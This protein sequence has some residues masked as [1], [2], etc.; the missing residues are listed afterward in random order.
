MVPKS[1]YEIRLC[2][3]RSDCHDV[4]NCIKAAEQWQRLVGRVENLGLGE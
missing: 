4:T 1:V 3:A 2:L